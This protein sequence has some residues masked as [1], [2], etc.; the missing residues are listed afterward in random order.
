MHEAQGV[1]HR[2]GAQ[3]TLTRDGT[4]AAVGQRGRQHAGA[5]ARHLDGAQLEDTQEEAV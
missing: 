2:L 3:H 5:L 1:P 4:Q